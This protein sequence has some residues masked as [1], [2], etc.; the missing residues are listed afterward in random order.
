MG[1]NPMNLSMPLFVKQLFMA[2]SFT[3]SFYNVMPNGIFRT[4]KL[5]IQCDS[6]CECVSRVSVSVCEMCSGLTGGFSNFT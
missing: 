1:Y 2:H 5:V 4:R 3:H 6:I